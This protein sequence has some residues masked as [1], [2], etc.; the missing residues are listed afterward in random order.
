MAI[1][2]NEQSSSIQTITNDLSAL[3]SLNGIDASAITQQVTA[4][5]NSISG[6]SA[7]YATVYGGATTLVSGYGQI[8]ATTQA[9]LNGGKS[10]QAAIGSAQSG[11]QQLAGRP[12]P[13]QQRFR[14]IGSRWKEPER[15]QYPA[16]ACR[17]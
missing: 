5:Q 1:L 2:A 4:L 12:V 7:G 11:S 6:L 8:G 9:L 14:T 3:S 13:T 16:Q 15:R 10:L 17:L